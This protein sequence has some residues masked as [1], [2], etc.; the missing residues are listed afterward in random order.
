M[1]NY[2]KPITFADLLKKLVDVDPIEGVLNN[3]DDKKF[4]QFYPFRQIIDGKIV[5]A[6]LL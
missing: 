2:F 6:D 3:K 4:V 5:H 1:F